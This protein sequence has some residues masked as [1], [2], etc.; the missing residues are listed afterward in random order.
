MK[1]IWHDHEVMQ[2]VFFLPAIM[3]KNINKKRPHP[4]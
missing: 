4:V 1:V 3:Q 2:E